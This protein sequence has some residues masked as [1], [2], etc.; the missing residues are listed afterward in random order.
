MEIILKKIV[1]SLSFGIIGLKDYTKKLIKNLI[2]ID[3]EGFD[4][5]KSLRTKNDFFKFSLMFKD[6]LFKIE[7]LLFNKI[8]NLLNSNNNNNNNLPH[9]LDTILLM[10]NVN[11]LKNIK[12]YKRKHIQKINQ[13]LPKKGTYVLIGVNQENTKISDEIVEKLIERS[14]KLNILYCF[15]LE[16]EEKDMKN[17]FRKLLEDYV[18]NFKYSKPELFELAKN[19]SK[20]IQKNQ[21]SFLLLE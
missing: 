11:K 6:V 10:I 18:F 17:I 14:K 1:Y 16:D 15:L 2:K 9:K 13:L 19:Y 5:D 4:S 21:E 20:E 3:T 8:K 7:I 12:K